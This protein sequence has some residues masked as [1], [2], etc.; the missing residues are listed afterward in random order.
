MLK[1][2]DGNVDLDLPIS[3]DTSSPSFGL[4][5]FLT[6][7]VK[8]ATIAGAKEYLTM[9]FVPYASLVKIVLA[10]DRHLLKLEISNLNYQPTVV[11][12]SE[13][14]EA[15]LTTFADL[16]KDK[17]DLQIKLCGVSNAEDLG[18]S[19][20][21]KLNKDEIETLINISEQRGNNFKKYM[22]EEKEISSSRL[23]LCKPRI[24]NGVESIP[25]IRFET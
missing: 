2:S 9:T 20:G 17:T 7:I 19:K 3:G 16:L 14:Q 13:E 5:G 25:H 1:D 4:S 8:R 10:A 21:S 18:K 15:F 6:L 11:E 12:V 22:V 24:N 23:L